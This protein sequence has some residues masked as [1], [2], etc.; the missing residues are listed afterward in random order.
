MQ[1]ALCIF[2]TLME[3]CVVALACHLAAVVVAAFRQQAAILLPLSEQPPVILVD[4]QS[5]LQP[6]TFQ[7][8]IATCTI[9][10]NRPT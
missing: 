9:L 10:Q 2:G 1:T 8:R 7:Y 3:A 5:V 4:S 6:P